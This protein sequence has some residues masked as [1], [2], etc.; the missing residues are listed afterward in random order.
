MNPRIG[1]TMLLVTVIAILAAVGCGS[2]ATATPQ[3]QPLPTAKPIE[4]DPPPVEPP[5]VE[6]AAPIE[7]AS[8]TPPSSVGGD[9]VLNI[10]SGL[11]NGCAEFNGYDLAQEGNAF[12]VSVKNLVPHPSLE[13]ACT[14]QYGLHEGQIIIGSGL[15][16]GKTYTVAVN[17]HLML[18]FNAMDAEGLAMVEKESPVD[19][20]EVSEDGGGYSLSVISRLPKGSSCSRFSG[21]TINNRFLERIEVSVS[22]REV[23]EDNVPCTRDLPVIVTDIPLGTEFVPGMTYTVVVNG[24]ETGFPI[25]DLAMVSVQAPIE[26]ATLVTPEI[27]DGVYSIDITSGLPSGCAQFNDVEISRNGNEFVV[28]VTNLVPNPTK[29]I[30]CTTIYGYHESK[31]I[32]GRGLTSGEA[33]TVVING[34]L[35]LLFTVP[36]PDGMTM[37]QK[38]SPIQSVAVDEIDGSYLLVV[39][40]TLPLGSACS[41][42]DGYDINRRFFDRVEV[43]VTHLEITAQN[44]PCTTDLPILETVIPLDDDFESGR[45]YTVSANGKE[46]SFVAR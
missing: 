7:D 23:S 30:A 6:V 42:F 43:T 28:D 1:I 25:E 31:A 29:P 5:P 35:T 21:Y 34:E 44:V 8:V 37:V 18:S 20:V 4:G 12:V 32:L 41:K 19:T 10:T 33:Y 2:S 38:E 16:T 45:T 24:I 26:S 36:Q 13:M 22:H 9:Y 17:D 3:V 46:A 14:E 39:V 40:S 27:S 11:S 15:V